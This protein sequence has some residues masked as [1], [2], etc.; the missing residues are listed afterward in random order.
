MEYLIFNILNLLKTG[1][2][3]TLNFSFTVIYWIVL[4]NLSYVC[5]ITCGHH[6]IGNDLSGH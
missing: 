5:H 2:E 1:K 4:E 6:L 3:K